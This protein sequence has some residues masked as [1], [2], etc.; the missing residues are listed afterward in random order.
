MQWSPT[1]REFLGV[2]GAGSLAP[3]SAGTASRG[4]VTDAVPDHPFAPEVETRW[5]IDLDDSSIFPFE[6]VD[7]TLYV[8]TPGTIHAVSTD[9]TRRWRHSVDSRFPNVV[10]GPK[11]A[12][13]AADRTVYVSDDKRVYALDSAEGVVRWRYEGEGRQS[14]ISAIRDVAVV[15]DDDLAAVS[16][17]D[18]RERWRFDLDGNLSSFPCYDGHLLYV[19]TNRGKLYALDPVG[20][21]RWRVEL[22]E[23]DGDS[24]SEYPHLLTVETTADLV[25][26]WG[27][28]EGTL[29]A[30]ETDDGTERWRV[31]TGENMYWFPGIVYSDTVY[32][33]DRNTLRA[34]S[35]ADGIERWRFDAESQLGG[36]PR[37]VDDT[38]YVGSEDRIYALSVAKGRER[39]RSAATTLPVDAIAGTH[40]ATDL[41]N[42]IHGLSVDDGGV[43]WRYDLEESLVMP[44]RVHDGSVY[45]G[46]ESGT[47][48]AI[49]VPGSSLASDAYRTA[50]SPAGLAVSGLLGGA[51]AVG[52]YRRRNSDEA[53]DDPPVPATFE[54][55]EVVELVAETEV[56]EVHEARTPRGER[57]ALKRFTPGELSEEQFAEAIRTWADLN[58]AGVL[59]IREWG[60][61]PVPWVVTEYADATLPDR[62]ADLTTE[63]FAHAVADVA[64]TVHRAHRDGVVH[65]RLTP[66]SVWFVD[67]NVR[68]GDWRLAAELR[69]S[70]EEVTPEDDTDRLA[71]MA[72]DLLADGQETAE[73]F[74]VLSRVP[75]SDSADSVAAADSADSTNPVDPADPADRYDSLLKFADALRW[76]VRE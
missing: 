31:R 57:V 13:P 21:E 55:Y 16:A 51:L 35:V 46:T 11:S 43:R 48:G 18:G 41:E 56:A 67:G 26:A 24:E 27:S 10:V 15:L 9:G 61:D 20:A 33:N 59:E 4:N 7:D 65:G 62:T 72:R 2:A 42:S 49:S 23:R 74:E 75:V 53:A 60:T 29:Y 52:A 1:R 12:P 36:I 64:E 39:W 50:T 8:G 22:P 34:F 66:E 38:V 5:S 32:V 73:L 63:E 45:F 6:L 71:E 3:A 69:R 47:L 68:V 44:P 58:H 14:V 28:E 54:D 76:A 17:S 40:V 37:A 25:F 19:G 70:D 30:F